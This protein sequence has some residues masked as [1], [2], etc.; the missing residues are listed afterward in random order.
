[1]E[2]TITRH[3]ADHPDVAYYTVATIDGRTLYQTPDAIDA[4]LWAASED[5]ERILIRWGEYTAV[6]DPATVVP[7]VKMLV[8]NTHL[9]WQRATGQQPADTPPNQHELTDDPPASETEDDGPYT[10]WLDYQMTYREK[11]HILVNRHGRG[12]YVAGRLAEIIDYLTHRDINTA[13]VRAGD[14]TAQLTWS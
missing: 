10:I 3:G 6:Y 7:R 2:L 8:D 11:R 13:T 9:R 12:V 1:M 5:P 14:V 4:A